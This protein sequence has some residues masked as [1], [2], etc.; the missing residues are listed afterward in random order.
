MSCPTRKHLSVESLESKTLLAADIGLT[1]MGPDPQGVEVAPAPQATPIPDDPIV[2]FDNEGFGGSMHPDYDVSANNNLNIHLPGSN[3]PDVP[4]GFDPFSIDS[5]HSSTNAGDSGQADDGGAIAP[6]GT[7]GPN[8]ATNVGD[9]IPTG[10]LLPF[11]TDV[12]HTATDAGTAIPADG[13]GS[14]T[15]FGPESPNEA[16]TVGSATPTDDSGFDPLGPDVGV[17]ATDY[18][19]LPNH[20]E[21]V[22]IVMSVYD[23]T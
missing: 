11:G 13:G 22:D 1:P 2:C 5:A 21:S 20:V 6:H 12:P 14:L 4:A 23:R 15:P 17:Q 16:T 10:T 7:D 9:A 19:S 18:G 8:T 3:G